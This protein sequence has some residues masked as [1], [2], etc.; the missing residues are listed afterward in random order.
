MPKYAKGSQEAKDFMRMVREK[1][2][3]MKKVKGD[4]FMDDMTG[5]VKKAAASD[6]GKAVLN[7]G[8]EI[9][10]DYANSKLKNKGIK[11]SKGD[12]FFSDLGKNVGAVAGARGGPIG[13]IV[14]SSL[15][16]AGGN[17][18]DKLLGTG[19]KKRGRKS[20]GGALLPP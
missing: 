8:V 17:Q 3:G 2:K 16:S 19:I 12:G 9:G 10:L 15:G 20:K 1:R 11:I 18:V 7:K 5:M 14:A 4:G 13:S 6:L